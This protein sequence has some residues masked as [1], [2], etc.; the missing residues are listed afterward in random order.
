MGNKAPYQLLYEDSEI[1]VVY[2]E[3]DV[4]SIRTKAKNT[5]A[6]NLYHYLREYLQRKNESLYIVH[7][8]DYE[9]SGVM[10]FAK[11][12]EKQVLLQSLFEKHLVDR[13][14]EAVIKEPLKEGTSFTVKQYLKEVG[15]KVLLSDEKEG[16]LAITHIEAKNPIQIGTALKIK[17]DTGRHNQIRIALASQGYTLF[18]DKR[19]SHSTAKR[20][21]LNSYALI[22]PKEAKLTQ[23]EFITKPLWLLSL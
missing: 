4:F 5:F 20:L 14:Y 7:R 18:G 8:L 19:Y 6:H 12:R 21:Y 17:I 11:S 2:K 15:S 16:K 3:R 1:L 9:T 13:Y 22:F 23:S 10:I